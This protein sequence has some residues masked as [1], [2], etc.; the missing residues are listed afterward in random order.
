MERE[1][2][3]GVI[4][5]ALLVWSL[6]APNGACFG[7]EASRGLPDKWSGAWLAPTCEL[8]PLQ[9]IHGV[10]P[11]Q[12][13]AAAMATLKELGLGGIVCNVNFAEYLR[14][15]A[16]WAT[17]LAAV[18]GCRQAGLRVWIYD[19]EGYPSGSAGGLVLV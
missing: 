5:I 2:G 4:A 18:E 8:R 16:Y 17:L 14:S 7:Q 1:L 6:A 10:P 12:A 13:T 15:E 9:I 11:A 3:F 19:E